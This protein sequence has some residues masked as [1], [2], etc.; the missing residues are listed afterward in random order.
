MKISTPKGKYNAVINEIESEIRS[1]EFARA[2]DIADAII[3][4][5]NSYY[6]DQGKRDLAAVINFMTGKPLISYIKERKMMC[7][8][9]KLLNNREKCDILAV[10]DLAGFSDQQSF[11]KAFKKYFNTTPQKAWEERNIVISPP[12]TWEV[13]SEYKPLDED[14]VEI[15]VTRMPD[16]IFG[17]SQDQYQKLSKVYELRSVYGF[18]EMLC[19]IAYDFSEEKDITIEDVFEYIESFDF[20][21]P[22]IAEIHD[23]NWDDFSA[24]EKESIVRETINDRENMHCFFKFGI[25]DGG[26]YLVDA[27]HRQ[28]V[29]DVTLEDEDVVRIWWNSFEMSQPYEKI[30]DAV[31]AYYEA[32]KDYID[33]DNFQEFLDDIGMGMTI[34]AALKA[35]I[36]W[37]HFIEDCM[38]DA[39][40]CEMPSKYE[41]EQDLLDAYA[42]EKMEETETAYNYSDYYYEP[43]MDN[44]YYDD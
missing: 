32:E 39:Y 27:L 13:V 4:S 36:P 11:T 21:D 6:G 19:R 23:I 5:N 3:E 7:S 10:I 25:K 28:G 9:E 8:C 15:E 43:D 14:S 37:A 31:L 2:K 33:D 30:R 35:T 42:M 18:D 34:E 38:A 17:M 24:E 41:F 22:E 12:Q 40:S 26:D 20:F 1:D 16:S 29:E 44:L